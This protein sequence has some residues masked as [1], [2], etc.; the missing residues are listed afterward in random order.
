MTAVIDDCAI[1]VQ[2]TSGTVT[3]PLRDDEIKK[4]AAAELEALTRHLTKGRH[5]TTWEPRFITQGTLASIAKWMASGVEPRDA[6]SRV[7]VKSVA[8]P[9]SEYAWQDEA[10]DAV[11]AG[12]APFQGVVTAEVEK[13]G[14][15]GYIHG[16]VCVRPPCGTTGDEIS[17]PDHGSGV[18]TGFND[19][20]YRARFSDG[21][22][23]ILGGNDDL[24]SS[25][26]QANLQQAMDDW[27]GFGGRRKTM[28]KP[29]DVLM[30]LKGEPSSESARILADE[31]KSNSRPAKEVMHRGMAVKPGSQVARKLLA[32]ARKG[33]I[34]FGP[35][36]FTHDEE[37]AHDF[38][39]DAY[40]GSGK[41]GIQ[42]N[43]RN[44]TGIPMKPSASSV[45]MGGYTE[46]EW[47]SGGR[48]RVTG[49]SGPLPAHDGFA[50]GGYVID[51]EQLQGLGDI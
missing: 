9:D 10:A 30:A 3:S 49:M 7:T 35:S 22:A 1:P 5:I 26:D 20:G 11:T 25:Q 28:V 21:T 14:A 15:E 13:V 2:I 27:V 47:L 6:V 24:R 44:M 46:S 31:L 23:G 16:W 41:I 48:Y 12:N 50:A 37:V 8:L 38:M 19:S 51:A 40:E 4:R 32:A 29:A 18:I 34:D 36:S 39:G 45:E 42:V 33:M 17:H 43:V